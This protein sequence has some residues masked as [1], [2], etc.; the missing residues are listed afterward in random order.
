[1]AQAISPD[2][3][4]A[5]GERMRYRIDRL[6]GDPWRFLPS[7]SE[8]YAALFEHAKA[9]T[10][11]QAYAMTELLG[12][13]SSRYFP[14]MPP[15]AE[16][17]FPE[18]NK[19]D[20]TSQVGWYYFAGH[21]EG[22]DGKRYGV[23]CMLFRNALMPPVMAEHFALNETDNQ[24][25]EVQLAIA[26]GGGKFYQIDPPVTAGTSGKV[27]LADKLC[28]VTEGGSAESASND[29]LFPIRV[30][31]S[32][33]DRSTGTPV[34]LTIDLTITSARSYLPQGNDGAEPL[35]GGLGTRYYSIPG[36]VI[37]PAKSTIKVGEQ[38]IALKSGTLWF[39]H[40]WGLGLAPNGS[41]RED[42]LRAAG[43]LNPTVSR[44]W[45]FFVANFF[46]G[47]RSLTLNSIHDD[48]SVPFLNMTGPKPTSALHAPVIGK[49]M[50][51]FGVLFNISGTVTIDDWRKTGPAPDPKKFPNTPTWVP[52]HWIFTLTEGVVPQ[53]LRKLEARAICD[54][55]NALQFANGARYVEAAV[56]YFGADGKAVG[57]GYAE[58]V[59]YLNA[60][61]T[62]LN[63]AGLPTTPE[64][65]AL[66]KEEPVTPALWLES[67]LYML[68]PASQAELKRL[69][70]CAQFPPG[71]R[72]LDCT[73]PASP[74]P[75]AEAIHPDEILAM[76]RKVLGKG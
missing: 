24:L 73:N 12:R 23:L 20:A 49:Y 9:L 58:A 8:R 18:V 29:S 38:K 1:M 16:L 74:A 60:T 25:V 4:A 19:V 69:T 28:L 34:D 2:S 66:F 5:R 50:D 40:Q 36:L 59:G 70:A 30:Q 13:D 21:C 22:I 76:L 7:Y 63:L 31:A 27:K 57:T 11:L 26:V 72:P 6:L 33:T 75:A 64:V 17:R 56:D 43:N 53:N 42:V 44:G 68:S 32:G 48:T 62:R 37:D 71:P 45:D 47:P 61:V 51:A 39:D 15:T 3:D 54:D 55:A 46:E 41:P 35:I 52:H 10:P 67:F 14:D 65:Q